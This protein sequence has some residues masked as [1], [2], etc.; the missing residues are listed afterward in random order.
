MHRAWINS[1][2]SSTAVRDQDI[3][4]LLSFGFDERQAPPPG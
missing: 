2:K 4:A 3:A 1:K